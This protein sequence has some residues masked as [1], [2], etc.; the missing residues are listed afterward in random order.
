M[1]LLVI[2]LIIT[3]T[4]LKVNEPKIFIFVY[5]SYLIQKIMKAVFIVC[6]TFSNLLSNLLQVFS[7]HF[8]LLCSLL[9]DCH[10]PSLKRA[11]YKTIIMNESN[12]YENESSAN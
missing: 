9:T 1:L 11:F 6:F 7:C 10:I 5:M 8:L 12:F 4:G 2:H 3:H